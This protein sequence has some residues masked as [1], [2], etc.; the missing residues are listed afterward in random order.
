MLM[1]Y[2]ILFL[3]LTCVGA[4]AQDEHTPVCERMMAADSCLA[5]NDTATALRYFEETDRLYPV[6]GLSSDACLKLG[7]LY[8]ALGRR[9]DAERILQKGLTI[10]Y[11]VY[12]HHRRYTYQDILKHQESQTD[13]CLLFSEL[14]KDSPDSVL[15]YVLWAGSKYQP[16]YTCGNQ[17]EDFVARLS[18]RVA[19][20]YL[21]RGDT[22]KAFDHLC[23]F[24]LINRDAAKKLK[25]M[26]LQRYSQKDIDHE[27]KRCR[28][29][30][31]KIHDKNDGKLLVYS[32]FGHEILRLERRFRKSTK[33]W[34]TRN[35]NILVLTSPS[36]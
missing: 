19:Q 27:L 20:L 6:N 29:H 22:A 34:L 26:L 18:P 4:M 21:E 1:R 12:C 2:A 5:Q 8:I 17:S 24:L 3:L 13:I 23:Q 25:S 35:K 16:K 28:S 9:Q 10:G 11:G 7:S 32:M 14:Y 30:P 33:V 15:K 31:Q 36:S